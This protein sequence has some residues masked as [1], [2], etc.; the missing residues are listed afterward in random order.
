MCRSSDPATRIAGCTALIKSGQNT[1]ENLS[2]IYNY[3]GTAYSRKGDHALAIQDFSEAIR[4]NPHS[5]S[6][7]YGRGFAYDYRGLEHDNRDD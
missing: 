7:Y 6:A 3:R 4:L 1:T 2:V 5:A